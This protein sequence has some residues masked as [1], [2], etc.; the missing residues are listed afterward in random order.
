MPEKFDV[1]VVSITK[2]DKCFKIGQ[3]KIPGYTSSFHLNRAHHDEGIMS[4]IREDIPVKLLSDESEPIEGLY[5]E[6]NGRKK[7]WLLRCFYNPNKNKIMTHLDAFRRK[8]DLYST[9]YKH[10]ILLDDFKIESKDHECSCFSKC[11]SLRI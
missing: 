6:L 8:F 4:F 5:T 11:M 10:L 1:L 3:F 2:L 7:K 9:Q